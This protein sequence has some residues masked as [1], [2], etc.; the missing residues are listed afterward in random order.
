[1]PYSHT[2]TY[3]HQCSAASRLVLPGGGFNSLQFH[4]HS[5]IHH[6]PGECDLP[7]L[8]CS[9][10]VGFDTGYTSSLFPLSAKQALARLAMDDWSYG[11]AVINLSG[12]TSVARKLNSGSFEANRNRTLSSLPPLSLPSSL[13]S[14]LFPLLFLCHFALLEHQLVRGSSISTVSDRG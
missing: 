12:D 3:T 10:A 5:W 4:F 11:M 1:M 13:S 9:L 2:H 6:T 14:S 7:R 8:A